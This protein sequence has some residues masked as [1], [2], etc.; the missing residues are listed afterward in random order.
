MHSN[1]K[2]INDDLNRKDD[3]D[4]LESGIGEKDNDMTVKK[5]MVIE[6]NLKWNKKTHTHFETASSIHLKK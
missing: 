4:R 5:R 6:C 2:I 3:D 1:H